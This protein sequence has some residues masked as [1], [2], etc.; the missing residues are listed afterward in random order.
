MILQ[1]SKL[2]LDFQTART[3]R[4]TGIGCIHFTVKRN[5]VIDKKHLGTTDIHCEEG[6][7]WFIERGESKWPIQRRIQNALLGLSHLVIPQDP[8]PSPFFYTIYTLLGNGT[9]AYV[10][11]PQRHIF[12]YLPQPRKAINEFVGLSRCGLQATGDIPAPASNRTHR[13]AN[14]VI[15]N[16]I[17][18]CKRPFIKNRIHKLLDFQAYCGF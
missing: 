15:L 18:Q 9:A 5:A 1:L 14:L 17:R 12:G 3:P 16:W 4:S 10:T 6:Y 2:S 7:L 8:E 13:D 11:M